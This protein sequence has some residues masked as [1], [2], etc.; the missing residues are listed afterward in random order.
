MTKQATK[1]V[2]KPKPKSAPARPARGS[3]SLAREIHS[4]GSLAA[5]PKSESLQIS[6]PRPRIRLRG[7]LRS[8]G[9]DEWKI[10]WN[11]NHKVDTLSDSDATGDMKLLLDYLKE[12]IRHL[13]P[14]SARAAAQEPAAVEVVH[15]VVRPERNSG[16]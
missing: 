1:R 11:L 5:A 15:Q 3:A 7:A 9:L 8:V 2:T 4:A 14:A 10:A 16:I 12:A 6:Q 13:D